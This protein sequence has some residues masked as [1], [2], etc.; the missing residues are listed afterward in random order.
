M[1][2]TAEFHAKTDAIVNEAKEKTELAVKGQ[3]QSARLKN[4]RENRRNEREDE[5]VTHAWQL[6]AGEASTPPP[7]DTTTQ[8]GPPGEET[9]NYVPP[10]QSLDAIRRLREQKWIKTQEKREKTNG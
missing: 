1:R 4:V 9:S 6:G 2:Q 5:R 3:N 10:D 7:S 8:S